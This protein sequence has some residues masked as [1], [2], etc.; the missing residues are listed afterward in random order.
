MEWRGGEAVKYS[1]MYVP[2]EWI[3]TGLDWIGLDSLTFSACCF[4]LSTWVED[5]TYGV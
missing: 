4:F 5:F 2:E 1:C 3:L